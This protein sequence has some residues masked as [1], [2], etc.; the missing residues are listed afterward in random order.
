M[1][2]EELGMYLCRVCEQ[3]KASVTGGR[4]CMW[5]CVSMCGHVYG[6]VG[7]QNVCLCG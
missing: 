3:K 7:A 4:I 6:H 1:F 5:L 2:C